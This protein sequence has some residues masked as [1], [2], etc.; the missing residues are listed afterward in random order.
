MKKSITMQKKYILS[1][2]LTI[3]QPSVKIG[4]RSAAYF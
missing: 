3:R 1:L 4:P 2:S